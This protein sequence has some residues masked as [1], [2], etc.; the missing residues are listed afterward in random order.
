M[1]CGKSCLVSN[2]F[3]RASTRAVLPVSAIEEGGARGG[4]TAP[5]PHGGGVQSEDGD[6][7]GFSV[8][9]TSSS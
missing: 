1:G 7:R 9:W 5:S 2:L 4:A 6:L 3:P 8:Y